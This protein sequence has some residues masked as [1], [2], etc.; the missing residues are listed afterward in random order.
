MYLTKQEEAA[1]AGEYGEAIRIAFEVIVKVG[2]A[3]GAQKLIPI[4]HAHISGISYNNIGDPGLKFIG[5]IREKGGKFKVPTTINPIGL[6]LDDPR[7]IPGATPEFIRKQKEIIDNLVA[8]GGKPVM[9]CTPYYIDNIQPGWH[10]AWG[11]SSAVGYANTYIGAWTNREGGPLALMAAISGETYYSGVHIPKNRYPRTLF[12]IDYYEN[13]QA[14]S[15]ILGEIVA[16]QTRIKQPLLKG[17]R[18]I[19]EPEVKSMCAAAGAAGNIEMCVIPGITKVPIDE[20]IIE[21]K[22]TIEKHDILR[23]LEKYEPAAKPDIVFLG[24][25]HASIEELED[26]ARIAEKHPGIA[27]NNFWVAVSRTVYNKALSMGIIDLLKRKNIRVMRDTCIVVSPGWKE[28][29]ATVATNSYKT[30]FYMKRIHGLESYLAPVDKLVS[31]SF[32]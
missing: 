9:T 2:E 24:C 26:L 1:L 14:F 10:L 6:D 17:I 18:G 29:R 15:S 5:E 19:R 11:E 25:P 13:D 21:E 22:I 12:E 27:T 4:N 20:A 3:L 7:G 30:M 16:K 23:E 31:L 32:R 8:M 28:T